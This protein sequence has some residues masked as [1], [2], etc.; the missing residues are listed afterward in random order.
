MH[1]L[2]VLHAEGLDGKP[3]YLT[4]ANWFRKA[5]EY[6]VGDSQY[7]LAILYARGMGVEKNLP[8]AWAW[9]TAA[10]AQGDKDSAQKRDEITQRLSGVQMTA[11]KALAEGFRPRTADPAVNQVTT[12]P[13]SW[14]SLSVATPPKPATATATPPKAKVSKL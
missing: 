10:A 3:D 5:A 7:N 12:A 8:A 11:A 14:E 6:G 9:F 13:G 1:N 4:A 2:G